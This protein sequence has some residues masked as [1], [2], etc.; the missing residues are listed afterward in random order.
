LYLSRNAAIAGR[1]KLFRGMLKGNVQLKI[2][3]FVINIT[4]VLSR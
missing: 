1:R 4:V 2:A 3:A